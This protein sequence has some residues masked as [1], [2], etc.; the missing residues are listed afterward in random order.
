MRFFDRF[1]KRTKQEQNA[2]QEKSPNIVVY[3]SS[4]I[5]QHGN[6]KAAPLGYHPRLIGHE[7]RIRAE[8]NPAEGSYINES[9]KGRTIIC[10]WTNDGIDA[11]CF[12][13][14]AEALEVPGVQ[15]FPPEDMAWLP[16]VLKHFP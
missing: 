14:K 15:E 12:L 13:S 6:A 8:Q 16:R 1:K 3:Y 10:C 4:S 5:D 11:V 7:N 2:T 9:L